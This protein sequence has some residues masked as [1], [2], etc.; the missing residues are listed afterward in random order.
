[1]SIFVYGGEPDAFDA[2]HHAVL[3]FITGCRRKVC[4]N[5]QNPDSWAGNRSFQPSSL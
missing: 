2:T 4:L 1:M 5:E 3:V